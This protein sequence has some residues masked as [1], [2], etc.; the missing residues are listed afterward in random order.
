[1][2]TVCTIGHGGRSID[3]FVGLLQGNGIRNVADVRKLPGSNRYPQYNRDTLRQTLA[4]YG[5]AYCHIP[6]LGG[7]R[8]RTPD[9]PPER[10]ALWRNRSFHR[11]AD[12]M[13]TQDFASGLAVLL[14]AARQTPTTVMCAETLW[15][16]CHRRL[17]ADALT[18]Y[19]LPVV[20]IL[21]LHRNEPAALTPGAI[22]LPDRTLAYPA[23]VS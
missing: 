18:V 11:Y 19:G 16:R 14:S 7:L 13:S 2:N 6:G 22:I 1:M 8:G 20:H 10:N 15:W 21:S 9:I 3:E 17:I 5:I 23:K 4:G 12:Y